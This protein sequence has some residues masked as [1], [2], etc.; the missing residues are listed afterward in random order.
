MAKLLE[1]F[2]AFIGL[3]TFDHLNSEFGRDEYKIRSI[4]NILRVVGQT[5]KLT[6]HGQFQCYNLLKR[7]LMS[8]FQYRKKIISFIP[9]TKPLKYLSLKFHQE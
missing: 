1:L 2:L 8:Y 5:M 3:V 7:T 6:C 4:N 9:L